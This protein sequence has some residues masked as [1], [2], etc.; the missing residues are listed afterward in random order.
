MNF[1]L[2][3]PVSFS[4]N[5]GQVPM[6]VYGFVGPIQINISCQTSQLCDVDAEK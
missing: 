4:T 1:I 2:H 6:P 5:I 3:P